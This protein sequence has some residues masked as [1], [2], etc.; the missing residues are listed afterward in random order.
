MRSTILK[1]TFIL[2]FLATA[3]FVK[4]NTGGPGWSY[5]NAP[6][7]SSSKEANCTNCHGSFSLQTSGTNHSRI[8]LTGNFTGNGYIPDSTYTILLTYKESNKSKF[9]YQM[10]VLEET[11]YKPAGTL[12]SPDSRTQTGTA[13]VGVNT[14]QYAGHTS[15]GSGTVATDS[16]A[17]RITWKAPNRNVGNVTF[18]VVVNVTDGGS[19]TNNDYVYSKSFTF[20][21]SNLLPTVKAKILDNN[22]CSFTQLTFGTDVTGSPTSYQWSFPSGTPSSSTAQNPKVQYN[23]SGSFRAIVSVKNSKGASTNDTLTFTVK[24]APGAPVIS[25]SGTHNICQGDSIRFTTTPS[26]GVTYAWSKGGFTSQSIWVKDS[27]VY[28]STI[29]SNS[30]GCSRTSSLPVRVNVNSKPSASFLSGRVM[31]TACEGKTYTG[32]ILRNSKADSISFVSSNGPWS[33]DTFKNYNLT[34]LGLD[35]LKAWVKN[36]SG[37]QIQTSKV[38]FVKALESGLSLSISN[39]TLTGFTVEWPAIS[40]ATGYNVSLDSGKTF[41]SANGTLSHNVSGLTGGERRM[42][43]AK[44]LNN[45]FCGETKTTSVEGRADTCKALNFNVVTD[46]TSYCANSS[47]KL[48]I[49]GMSGKTIGV[50]LNGLFL[51]SNHNFNVQIQKT[52]SFKVEVIDSGAVQCGYTEKTAVVH[53]D[54]VSATTFI[55]P[56]GSSVVLCNSGTTAP[57][58]IKMNKGFGQDSFAYFI[59][60]QLKG[61]NTSGTYNLTVSDND[62]VTVM[63]SNTRGCKTESPEILVKMPGIPDAAFTHSRD[64]YLYTFT[65]TSSSGKH[66]WYGNTLSNNDTTGSTVFNLE[67]F[68]GNQVKIYHT[69]KLN[70]CTGIDSSVINVPDITGLNQLKEYGLSVY[71]NPSSE[72]LFIDNSNNAMMQYALVSIEGKA[73]LNGMLQNGINKVD[74]SKIP[75]GTYQISFEKDGA[76]KWVSLV[77]QH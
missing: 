8:R 21:P 60:G 3:L 22:I 43:L 65:A 55:S 29:T 77:I 61:K 13:V 7:T 25:P 50:K 28:F 74:V 23:G 14:R 36:N 27:G 34:R 62:K 63:S 72:L 40:G 18:W 42:V 56:A 38:V 71:P 17:W 35:T 30:T 11:T 15:T 66:S 49:T 51:G 57:L 32:S 19:G 6:I 1:S 44:A 12:S 67:S 53:V 68:K 33:L 70:G 58:D 64:F 9:G 48:S 5:T 31:D 26:T 75:S 54:T 10:T 24:A 4:T 52:T 20:S 46:K 47:A 69:R 41:V 37:C 16:T 59:N 2:M 73:I 45:T 76:K 39:R